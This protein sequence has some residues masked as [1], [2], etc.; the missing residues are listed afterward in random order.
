MLRV[1]L[2]IL[3]LLIGTVVVFGQETEKWNPNGKFSGEFRTFFMNSI[4]KGDLKDFAALGIG[5]HLK[6]VHKFG[7][8]RV[9]GALY[10]NWNTNIQDLT[11]RD[12]TTNQLGRYETGMFDLVD[13]NNRFFVL[14]GELFVSYST[15]KHTLT[16]GR[17][18]LKTPLM[19]GQDGRMIPSLFQGAWYNYQDSS[20]LKLNAGI[21]NAI[22]P[23]GTSE[24]FGIGESFGIFGV[25]RNPDGT[26]SQYLGYTNSNFVAIVSAEIPVVENLT[27]HVWDYFVD[28]TFNSLYIKPVYK[29]PGSKLTLAAEWLHQDRVG[30]GGNA[31]DSLRYFTDESADVLGGQVSYGLAK[32]T[33][34]LGYNRIFSHGRFLFPREWGREFI[35]T[36][37]KRERSEGSADNHALMAA[38]DT[39][40]SIGKSRIRTIYSIGRQWKPSVLNPADN[41]YGIPSYTHFNFDLFFTSEKFPGL[42]PEILITYKMNN[43]NDFNDDPKFI[44]NRVDMW[45]L[46]FVLNYRF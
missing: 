22:S 26:R 37:Q 15:F 45:N 12:P 36:F 18:K 11:E 41:K 13:L 40:I 27:L 33:L 31:A 21:F 10:A 5:G 17:M 16:I 14:P 4:N 46:N 8:F 34:S 39:G 1:I 3:I 24:F 30:E 29:V 6:Y 38:Y 42:R 44:M 25:G 23:R 7:K 20:N 9:G 2:F 32:G 35:F 43:A 28:N 19:N